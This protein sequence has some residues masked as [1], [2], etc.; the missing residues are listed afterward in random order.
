MCLLSKSFLICGWLTHFWSFEPDTDQVLAS[1]LASLQIDSSFVSFSIVFQLL[2]TSLQIWQMQTLCVFSL[3]SRSE[4]ELSV[5]L[6]PDYAIVETAPDAAGVGDRAKQLI[7]QLEALDKDFKSLHFDVV[8]LIDSGATADLEEQDIL[9]SH[10]DDMTSLVVRL[11]QV[12]ADTEGI[13]GA[14][15]DD[16]DDVPLL[17]QYREQLAQYKKELSTVCDDL[18]AL[19]L[20][21]FKSHVRLE[22]LHFDCS[23]RVKKLLSAHSSRSTTVTTAATD[24]K[25]SRLPKLDIPTFNGDVLQL[26][27]FWEQ[28]QVSVHHRSSLSNAEKLVYLQLAIKDG[29]VRNAIEG[30]SRSGDHYHHEAIDC[31]KARYNRPRLIHRAHVRVP[32][33]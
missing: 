27:Q 30:L 23:H 18:V 7:S 22:S 6:L 3:N 16:H 10:D 14:V 11:Q 12:A 19:D 21:V 33:R 8:D 32:H 31:L 13:L 26:R 25:G 28:F 20:E 1:F 17:E 9:D 15:A 29:S 24:N 2:P 4:E 5:L